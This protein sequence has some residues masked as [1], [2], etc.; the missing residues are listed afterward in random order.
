MIPKGVDMHNPAAVQYWTELDR[1]LEDA[2]TA[3]WLYRLVA[4][5]CRVAEEGFSFNASAYA[6]LAQQAIGKRLLADMKM[7][8][9]LAVYRAEQAYAELKTASAGRTKTEGDF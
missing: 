8:N 4:D 9:P 2:G 7:A 1:M 6:L 5:D 3:L